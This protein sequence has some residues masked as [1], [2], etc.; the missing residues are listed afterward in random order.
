M[1][2]QIFPD[3]EAIS[4]KAA[5]MFLQFSERYISSANRFVVALSGG[6]T[7]RT[8][9]DILGSDQYRNKVDWQNVHI[10][11]VDERFVPP[12]HA[13][14]NYRMVKDNL[15]SRISIP[16]QNVHPIMTDVSF[17][18]L[19]AKKYEKDMKTFLNVSTNKIPEFD[20]ILLGIGEDGHTASLFPGSRVLNRRDHFVSS[21]IEKKISH[22]RITLTLSVITNARNIIFLVSGKNKAVAVKKIIEEKDSSLP[23]VLVKPE[24][25]K[26]FFLIDRD[27]SLLI[28]KKDK[29]FYHHH[30]FHFKKD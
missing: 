2:V 17:P 19:A 23:A 24:K 5:E 21:V 6:N 18:S 9:Y 28:S 10:F 15:L 22:P 25:G 12:D 1:N 30:F 7:P 3:L 16:H 14:S 4:R 11:W 29:S 26:L 27:A 20:L 8:F 13:D